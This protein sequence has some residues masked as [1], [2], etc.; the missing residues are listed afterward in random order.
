MQM[1]AQKMA[2]LVIDSTPCLLSQP[3]HPGEQN[4]VSN[5]LSFVGDICGY[6]HPL[7]HNFPSDS[8]L[9][10]RF[11]LYIPQLIPEGFNISPLP[12]KI[13][14]FVTQALQNIELSWV[15]NRKKPLKRRTGSGIGGFHSAPALAQTLT[16]SSLRYSNQKL[17]LSSCPFSPSTTWLNVVLQVPFL[18]SVEPRGFVNSAGCH[19]QFGCG[20]LES[21]PTESHSP[22][23]KHPATPHQPGPAEGF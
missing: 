12:S 22:S 8:V 11:Y 6:A 14:S 15:Q 21:L 9:T 1:I 7:A 3:T 17:S 23:R 4:T 20:I 2:H 10:N 13:S 18:A 16:L 5:L 19:R